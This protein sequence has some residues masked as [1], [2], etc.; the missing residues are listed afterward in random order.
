MLTDIIK[1][2][3]IIKIF[4]LNK[5]NIPPKMFLLASTHK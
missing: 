5:N 3:K 2:D 1:N 4:D